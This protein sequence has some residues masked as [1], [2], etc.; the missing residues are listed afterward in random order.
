MATP[1]FDQLYAEATD[2]REKVAVLNVRRLYEAIQNAADN[3]ALDRAA[4]VDSPKE[5]YTQLLLSLAPNY[6]KPASAAPSLG[7]IDN[8]AQYLE[9]IVEAVFARWSKRM[10]E[11]PQA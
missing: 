11:W 10:A 9:K 7:D 2:V 3:A 5:V 1:D 6:C 4:M 8:D